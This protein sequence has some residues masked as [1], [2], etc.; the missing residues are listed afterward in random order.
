MQHELD[1]KTRDHVI[2][3]AYGGRDANPNGSSNVVFACLACNM[4]RAVEMIEDWKRWGKESQICRNKWRLTTASREKHRLL[5]KWGGAKKIKWQ[6][7][8]DIAKQ[9][10]LPS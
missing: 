3:Q 1:R 7:Q 10:R 8:D 9:N 4:E 5:E 2:P 6:R